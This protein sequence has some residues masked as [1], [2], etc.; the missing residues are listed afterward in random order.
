M[1]KNIL[2]LCCLILF[3]TVTSH[4]VENLTIQAKFDWILDP[5]KQDR[6]ALHYINKFNQQKIKRP[7]M[8]IKSI[9]RIKTAKKKPIKKQPDE[10]VYVPKETSKKTVFQKN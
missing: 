1:S 3:S 6:F 7:A 10:F 4:A 9:R 8:P 2:C 5:F